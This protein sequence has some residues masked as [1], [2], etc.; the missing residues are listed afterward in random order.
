MHEEDIYRQIYLHLQSKLVGRECSMQMHACEPL[1]CLQSKLVGRECCLQDVHLIRNRYIGDV[2]QLYSGGS[3]ARMNLLQNIYDMFV[4]KN[5]PAVPADSST[6]TN[7]ACIYWSTRDFYLVGETHVP[8]ACHVCSICAR[9]MLGLACCT[10]ICMH[11]PASP[12]GLRTQDG[13]DTSPAR[14]HNCIYV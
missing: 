2:I 5:S 11:A 12:S 1:G 9:C 7:G 6:P 4:W 8:A 3:Y 14:V 13:C 10:C